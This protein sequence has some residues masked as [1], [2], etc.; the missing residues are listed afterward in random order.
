VAEV[1]DALPAA[2][3]SHAVTAT[4]FYTDQPRAERDPLRIVFAA[5]DRP[6]KGL[7]TLIDAFN[8]LPDG[9]HLD[10]VGPHR[11]HLPRIANPS[12]TWHG[13]L[14]PEELRRVYWNA[15]VFVSP[16]TQDAGDDEN[17]EPGTLDGFP[18]S[19]AVD[20]MSTGACLV[21]SNPRREYRIV[22]PGE[23]YIEIPERD[24]GALAAALRDLR[25]NPTQRRS[26]AARGMHR[27][28]ETMAVDKGVS[29]KLEVMGLQPRLRPTAM[30]S[31]RAD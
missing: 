12:F 23:H 3:F 22:R 6:R 9:Y 25:A 19:T 16:V 24:P 14:T 10:L 8:Q 15:D 5:D 26:V 28:R 27:I 1:T 4:N 30:P 18:T 31:A 7:R 2:H 13:W 17:S 29:R 11:R 20:A 21:S